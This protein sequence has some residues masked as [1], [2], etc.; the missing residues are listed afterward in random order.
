MKMFFPLDRT[1][2]IL[3]LS[4]FLSADRSITDLMPRIDVHTLLPSLNPESPLPMRVV[5]LK[6]S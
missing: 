4:V 5:R 1:F 2:R 3:K 6:L